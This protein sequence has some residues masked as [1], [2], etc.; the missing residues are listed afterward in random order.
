[1][2]D[3]GKCKSCMDIVGITPEE[4]AQI[5]GKTLK[6]K[7]I[8]LVTE[9]EYEQRLNICTECAYLDYGT[10]CRHC[11]CLVHIK[12]KIAGTHCPYPYSSKW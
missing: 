6:I 4:T 7:N 11:G 12:A 8:K 9:K 1:M 5:F 3:K 2:Q 10:T